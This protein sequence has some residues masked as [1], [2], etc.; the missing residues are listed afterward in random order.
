MLT[1]GWSLATGSAEGGAALAYCSIG[2]CHQRSGAQRPQVVQHVW[3]LRP[4]KSMQYCAFHGLHTSILGFFVWCCSALRRVEGPDWVSFC[5]RSTSEV[6]EEVARQTGPT[7]RDAITHGAETLGFTLRSPSSPT[8]AFPRGPSRSDIRPSRQGG[9]CSGN[10]VLISDVW[11]SS[12][13]RPQ[14]VNRLPSEDLCVLSLEYIYI[15]VSDIFLH[16]CTFVVL[17]VTN[18]FAC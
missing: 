17:F 14:N 8:R 16:T 3:P 18:C 15:F 10:E 7:P 12:L 2:P 11:A 4:P 5:L 9:D 13:R 6:V 1:G